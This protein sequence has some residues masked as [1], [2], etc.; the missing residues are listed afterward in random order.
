MILVYARIDA[1]VPQCAAAYLI[2]T[3]V[4]FHHEKITALQA[5]TSK[6]P[7]K[8]LYLVHFPQIQ[9]IAHDVC[10]TEEG[11]SIFAR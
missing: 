8:N 10:Y 1:A 7:I 3:A 5:Q 9:L 4:S 6:L 11:D 2:G